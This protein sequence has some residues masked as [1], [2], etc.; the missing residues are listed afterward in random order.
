MHA[1]TV[2]SYYY[3]YTVHDNFISGIDN[4]TTYHDGSCSL[5]LS[6]PPY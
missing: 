4:N 6:V 1:I 3:Q 5:T 2:V